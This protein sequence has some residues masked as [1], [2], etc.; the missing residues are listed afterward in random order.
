VGID[1][2]GGILKVTETATRLLKMEF[3]HTNLTTTK[4]LL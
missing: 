3:L 4:F 2:I 1:N